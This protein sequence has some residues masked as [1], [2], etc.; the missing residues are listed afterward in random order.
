MHPTRESFRRQR[1][2]IAR[3]IAEA[4]DAN[5]ELRARVAE[6]G[7]MAE[8]VH[9]GGNCTALRVPLGGG[10]RVLITDGDGPDAT[11][12]LSRIESVAVGVYH[13]EAGEAEA[14]NL[15]GV[16]GSSPAEVRAHVVMLVEQ[17][18]DIVRTVAGCDRY[19]RRPDEPGIRER[20]EKW[21]TTPGS[22]LAIVD[23]YARAF[24]LYRPGAHG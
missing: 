14:L 16:C 9:T 23:P 12:D 2:E 3:L 4:E 1:E 13:G 15:V 11:C 22:S 20:L 8:A 24:G 5:R 18:R 17:V 10:W 6:A 7:L 21:G 19:H